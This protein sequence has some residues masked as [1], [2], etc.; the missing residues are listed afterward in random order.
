[1]IVKSLEAVNFRNYERGKI[2]FG[3]NT[4]VIFGNNAQGK[5]NLLE[6]IYL[7][8]HGRSQR[9]KSDGELIKF[10][11]EFARLVLEFSDK[12][13][14]Y[15]AI[16]QLAKSGKKSIKI[17]NVPITKLS[18]LMRYLNVVM[19]SPEDLDIVKGAPQMRRRFLDEA[20]SQLYPMY[21]KSLISYHKNL[22]QKNN[23]LKKLRISS[24]QSDELL[25]VWNE[26]IAQDGAKIMKYRRDYADKLDSFA[27]L[28]HKE[29]SGEIFKLHYTPSIECDII[30][31]D[32]SMSHIKDYAIASVSILLEN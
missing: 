15:R 21:L 27:A 11:A 28:V 26:Q 22:A 20:I 7:F 17:N 29:M 1:M 19:F 10:G 6:A 2:C 8:S 3:E 12:D 14:S 32:I 16:F 18:M 30:S 9:A 23:L 4:N 24:K 31:K 25:S 5:T 13:R